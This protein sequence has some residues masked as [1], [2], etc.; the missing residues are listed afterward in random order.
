[1]THCQP[2]R[3]SD[4]SDWICV[5]KW[6]IRSKPSMVKNPAKI[7]DFKQKF[8]R[9]NGDLTGFGEISLDSLRFS[10]VLAEI[11]LDLVISPQIWHKSHKNLKYIWP[12][13]CRKI[14]VSPDFGKVPVELVE[15]GFRGENPPTDL[16]ELVS[17]FCNQPR[18]TGTL[19]SIMGGRFQ[20][21]P[22]LGGHP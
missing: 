9:S 11:S 13:T 10:P 2:M 15:A 4:Q 3:E 8:A 22:G 5:G 12:N 18:P 16:S 7:V 20:S 6:S 14:L 1:M 17:R 21:G 19:G